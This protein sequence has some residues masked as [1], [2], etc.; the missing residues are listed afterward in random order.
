MNNNYYYFILVGLFGIHLLSRADNNNSLYRGIFYI[1]ACGLCWES[2]NKD[3]AKSRFYSVHFIVNILARI[4][5]IIIIITIIIISI[6]CIMDLL[7]LSC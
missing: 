4:I 1:F 6:T 2:Y 3:F 7:I 5:I